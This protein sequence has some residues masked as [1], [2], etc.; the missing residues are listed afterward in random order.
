MSQSIVMVSFSTNF[1]S[2]VRMLYTLALEQR[3]SGKV[4]VYGIN[5]YTNY[6]GPAYISSVASVEAFLNEITFGPMTEALYKDSALYRLDQDWLEFLDIRPKLM[7]IP[8]LLFNSTF[9]RSV[10]PYQ[11]F[12]ILVAVRNDFVHYKMHKNPPRYLK[13]LEERSIALPHHKEAAIVW[14]DELSSSEGIRWAHNTS[15]RV[16][17]ALAQMIPEE[18]RHFLA[19]LATS[20]A[21]IDTSYVEKLVPLTKPSS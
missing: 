21:E 20:F 19:T 14:A 10:Q 11:D 7:L 16:V 5:S 4:S 18:H 9:S 12:D 8:Q 6:A 3:M 1:I 2:H 15:C 17:Q 13:A